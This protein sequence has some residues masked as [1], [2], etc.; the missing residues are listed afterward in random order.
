MS[1]AAGSPRL[2]AVYLPT[3][4]KNA[5]VRAHFAT[6]G[7][8]IV[9]ETEMPDPEAVFTQE[10]C[11]L[12]I[13]PIYIGKAIDKANFIFFV[14][15]GNLRDALGFVTVESDPEK[16]TI[17]IA[18][19]CGSGKKRGVG[20]PLLSA[21]DK[22]APILGADRILLDALV[23]KDLT[24]FYK[25]RGYKF[26]PRRRR[27]LF[28]MEK[29]LTGEREYNDSLTYESLIEAADAAGIASYGKGMK[30]GKIARTMNYGIFLMPAADPAILPKMAG[31]TNTLITYSPD[32]A[33][34]NKKAAGPNDIY[35]I[36][37]SKVELGEYDVVNKDL[38]TKKIKDEKWITDLLFYNY[39]TDPAKPVSFAL[40]TKKE[41]DFFVPLI[42]LEQ[43]K[44]NKTTHTAQLEFLE[45][46]NASMHVIS[47]IA[48]LKFEPD[49]LF[50][51]EGYLDPPEHTSE[52]KVST[53][54]KNHRGA[55]IRRR[56]FV[57]KHG[58]KRTRRIRRLFD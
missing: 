16:Q 51:M 30:K 49:A 45:V 58:G 31:I 18:V 7:Y 48:L 19:V 56:F 12:K 55:T 23:E 38:M 35:E 8:R 20:V 34:D 21:V 17:Y 52:S 25:K 27:D 57:Y 15:Q 41:S 6:Q 22:V 43:T 53:G 13:N 32:F 47:P 9:D 39:D 5:A 50:G 24:D 44:R 1:A 37:K 54:E 46:M 10:I 26:L 36:I 42:Y 33:K 40:L 14:Y 3:T 2:I 29:N 4:Y 28:P 11:Q